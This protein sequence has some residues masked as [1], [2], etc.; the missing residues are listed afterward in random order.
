MEDYKSNSDKS[1]QLA[2][3]K[4]IEPV[5]A[6]SAT[7]KKKSEFKKF[8]EALVTRDFVS[9]RS[10]IVGDVLIPAGKKAIEELVH[11]ILNG[12]NSRNNSGSATGASKVS[13]RSFWDKRDEA[14]R[15]DYRGAAPAQQRARSGYSYDD[16]SFDNI[17]D[18]EDVYDRMCEIISL[19]GVVSIA[20]LYDMARIIDDNYTNN[21]YGWSDIS[22][23]RY[24]PTSDNRIT[25]KMP[26]AMPI[27][28]L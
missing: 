8:T 16:V 19:Y 9:I 23:R 7:L 17:K 28:K 5:I 2:E 20:D 21:N 1:K 18:A 26:P 4:K 22:A 13:Y 12:E 3:V 15:A 25:L 11:M 6:G 14:L 24:I 10:Y 27:T